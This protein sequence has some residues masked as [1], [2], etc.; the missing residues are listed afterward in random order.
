[1]LGSVASWQRAACGFPESISLGFRLNVVFTW[2]LISFTE[3]CQSNELAPPVK[4]LYPLLKQVASTGAGPAVGE[5]ATLTMQG[6][7]SERSSVSITWELAGDVNSLA[8]PYVSWRLGCRPKNF[9][10]TALA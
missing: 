1:M 5:G 8:P 9:T 7:G 10:V 3:R 6:S 4:R 2:P